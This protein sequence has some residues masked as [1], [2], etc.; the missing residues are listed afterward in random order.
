PRGLRR[1]RPAHVHHETKPHRAGD[2]GGDVGDRGGGRLVRPLGSVCGRC[3][4]GPH[5]PYG[6]EAMTGRLVVVGTPLG[7]LGDLSPRAVDALRDADV[8]ACEDTRRTSN[9]LRAAGVEFTS[10]VVANDHTEADV[11]ARLVH[12]MLAG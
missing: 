8:I 12:T 4:D 7:N 2:D 11:A 3:G 1:H 9:L 5:G 10:L 6:G